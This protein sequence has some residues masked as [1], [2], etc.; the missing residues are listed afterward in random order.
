MAKSIA[1]AADASRLASLQPQAAA[2]GEE[3]GVTNQSERSS[4]AVP[5]AE[6][7]AS[8]HL[9]KAKNTAHHSS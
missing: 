7:I 5:A 1:F 2:Q 9:T 3:R 6:P 8:T 4:A